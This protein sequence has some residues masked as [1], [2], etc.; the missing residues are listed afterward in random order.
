MKVKRDNFIRFLEL[1]ALKGEFLNIETLLKIKG[2]TK[3]TIV[4]ASNIIAIN[5]IWKGTEGDINEV[6]VSNIPLLLKFLKSFSSEEIEIKKEDNKLVISSS[7]QKLKASCILKN[8]E[9]ILNNLEETKFNTLLEKAKGNEFILSKNIISQIS[10]YIDTVGSDELIFSYDEESKDLCLFVES[11]E[12]S[13]LASFPTDEKIKPF[14]TK[15]SKALVDILKTINDDVIIS[16]KHNTPILIKFHN[17]IFDI[18]YI[19]APKK[20]E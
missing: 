20:L 17:D 19:I 12:N 4:S 11:N 3:T 7:E 15:V 14:K 16:I 8:T 2:D 13:I 6:G 1:I 9:Y 5:A 18:T 10:I